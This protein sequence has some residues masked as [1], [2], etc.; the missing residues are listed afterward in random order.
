MFF[1][2]R[3]K[4]ST[5]YHEPLRR[6][7]TH[8]RNLSSMDKLGADAPEHKRRS[9]EGVEVLPRIKEGTETP[10]HDVDGKDSQAE[11]G[12]AAVEEGRRRH[13]HHGLHHHDHKNRKDLTDLR[14][15][16]QHRHHRHHRH[17]HRTISE[18]EHLE[19]RLRSGAVTL[20][21]IE[22]I[23]EKLAT[24]KDEAKLLGKRDLEEMACNLN[25]SYDICILE[26]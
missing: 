17:H 3:R 15:K 19:S 11:V 6:I 18:R 7:H 22:P 14:E 5:K 25:Y 26:M 10:D 16:P 23:Q 12:V 24:E 1:S 20:R 9:R 13:Q 21:E 4:V 8:R 2:G